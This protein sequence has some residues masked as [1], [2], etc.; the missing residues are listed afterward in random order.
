MAKKTEEKK[1]SKGSANIR[2]SLPENGDAFVGKLRTSY[3]VFPTDTVPRNTF[4]LQ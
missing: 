3:N 1:P 2:P 4:F